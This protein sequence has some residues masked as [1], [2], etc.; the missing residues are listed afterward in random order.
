MKVLVW[1][2]SIMVTA[3]LLFQGF[4]VWNNRMLWN[5][6]PAPERSEPLQPVYYP[7]GEVLIENS[8]GNR[9]WPYIAIPAVYFNTDDSFEQVKEYYRAWQAEN[10]QWKIIADTPTRLEMH[11]LSFRPIVAFNV[12]DAAKRDGKQEVV[13]RMIR[14]R[15]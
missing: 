8:L 11:D 4:L 9:I 13:L 3:A 1:V 5:S 14:E 15:C 10:P 7:H 2:A 12:S 6:C